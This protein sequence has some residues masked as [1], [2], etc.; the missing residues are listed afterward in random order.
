MGYDDLS[1]DRSA[2]RPDRPVWVRL[3]LLGVPSREWAWAYFGVS[4]ALAPLCLIA[5]FAYWRFVGGV[6]FFLA[7]WWY[8]AAIRWVDQNGG[9]ARP[10]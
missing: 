4:V 2:P 10:T 8:Y 1:A 9:W 5:A 7:A 3:G 6:V